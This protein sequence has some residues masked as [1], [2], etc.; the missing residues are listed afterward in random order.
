MKPHPLASPYFLA[1]CIGPIVET[2]ESPLKKPHPHSNPRPTLPSHSWWAPEA[3]YAWNTPHIH[4]K[5]AAATCCDCSCCGSYIHAYM[6]SDADSARGGLQHGTGGSPSAGSGEA[7]AAQAHSNTMDKVFGKRAKILIQGAISIK[8]AILAQMMVSEVKNVENR[9]HRMTPGWYAVQLSQT[10]AKNNDPAFGLPPDF[11]IKEHK[12]M[13]WT[14]SEVKARIGS[15]VGLIKVGSPRQ[16][17]NQQ[18]AVSAMGPW[19]DQHAGKFQHPILE[20]LEVT[21]VKH[22]GHLGVWHVE[23]HIRATIEEAAKQVWVAKKQELPKSEKLH[24][25][26]VFYLGR[27][28]P[29][30]AQRF[31]NKYHQR[32]LHVGTMCSGSDIPVKA[33]EHLARIMVDQGY[34]LKILHEF[35]C[36]VWPHTY[37]LLCC[38]FCFMGF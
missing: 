2:R 23:K 19:A 24:D 35:S 14:S 25:I 33:L 36:V 13:L 38:K 15:I 3:P 31:Y 5:I 34:D 6:R 22:K 27:L 9:S 28:K 4:N 32:T 26:G 10:A 21:P 7:P 11:N 29:H 17:L 30:Q 18:H 20:A 16:F 1:L 12:H 37:V 8:S